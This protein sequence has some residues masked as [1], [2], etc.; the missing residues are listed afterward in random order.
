LKE[1]ENKRG[2]GKRSQRRQKKTDLGS[3]KTE[4]E[5]T[6]V[7][8]TKTARIREIEEEREKTKKHERVAKKRNK[9]KS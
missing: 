5:P 4:K 6:A 2:K 8:R 3:N 7:R 9:W 1:R